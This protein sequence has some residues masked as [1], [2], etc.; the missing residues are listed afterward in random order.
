MDDELSN[1]KSSNLSYDNE[2]F[3]LRLPW[4][5]SNSD[6]AVHGRDFVKIVPG[7]VNSKTASDSSLFKLD[8][9][10]I[11]KVGKVIG[12]S[13]HSWDKARKHFTWIV[14]VN[15][16][17]NIFKISEQYLIGVDKRESMYT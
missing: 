14:N 12:G 3:V 6:Y 9:Q 4:V 2:N 5:G 11:G 8:K 1:F 13:I 10:L 15:L 16:E 17:N 7:R